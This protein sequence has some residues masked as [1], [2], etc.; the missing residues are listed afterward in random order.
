M[1]T[2]INVRSPFYLHLVEPSPPL[3]DFDCL[4]AFT[5]SNQT[6]FAVDNQGIITPPSTSAGVIESISSDDADFAN[7]KFPTESSDTTRSI[8]VNIAIPPALF[9]N[10]SD[11]FFECTLTTIQPG[12]TTSVVQ[13]TTC[14]GG[15]TKNGSIGGQTLTVGGSSVTIDLASFFN[16][17][18]VYDV[19]NV[20]PN[21]VTTALSGS[22]LTLS[23]NVIG[24][25]TT[26]YGIGRDASYPTTCEETQAISVTVNAGSALGCT[27]A[28]KSILQGGS[29]TAAGVIT[30]PVSPVAG[31]VEKSLTSGGT[32]ITSVS[33]NTGSSSQTVKLFY[34]LTPPATF[35]NSGTPIICE[36]DLQQAGTADPT[37]SCAIANLTGGGISQNGAILTPTSKIGATV[38]T[39]ASGTAFPTVTVDTSRTV[40]FPVTIPSGYQDAGTD[41]PGGCDV[42]FTQ[43]ATTPTCGSNTLYISTGAV[44]AP[45]DTATQSHCNKIQVVGTYTEI[46]ATDP[47]VTGV[48]D[49]VVC[50][51]GTPFDGRDL[52]YVITT[53]IVDA[54]GGPGISP[55]NLVKINR[56]GQVT[57]IA[58]GGCPT[59]SSGGNQA[60]TLF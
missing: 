17:A 59:P 54:A 39:P 22:S 25:T 2:K 12:I 11:G 6:G 51:N 9:A 36:I 60:G 4:V 33:A 52:Y 38:K 16:S 14:S 31:I 3:P 5:N 35:T 24:G 56:N 20:D 48:L 58:V 47:S 34:K 1:S 37:F 8:K 23:P 10:S 46:K 45:S 7:N 57:E 40:N 49:T 15:P 28:G 18:T 21:I 53:G 55:F 32:P 43:P 42:T 19:S 50:S 13:P 26:V 41:F 44:E 27:L 30:D 29:I